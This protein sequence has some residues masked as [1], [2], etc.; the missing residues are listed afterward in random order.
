MEKGLRWRVWGEN[1]GMEGRI[2]FLTENGMNFQISVSFIEFSRKKNVLFLLLFF[3]NL[4]H[5]FPLSRSSS[6]QPFYIPL[7]SFNT[8]PVFFPELFFFIKVVWFF[9][10]F[11]SLKYILEGKLSVFF[12]KKKDIFQID[13]WEFLWLGYNFFY[14]CFIFFEGWVLGCNGLKWEKSFF[15]GRSIWNDLLG[16]GGKKMMA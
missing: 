13:E 4:S 7:Y 16:R 12:K 11:V 8:P 9:L 3:W 2:G 10:C 5:F 14:E 1:G 6:C 15:K